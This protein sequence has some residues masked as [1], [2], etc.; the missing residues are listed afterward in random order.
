MD[1]AGV[2]RNGTDRN[3]LTDAADYGRLA[4]ET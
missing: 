3:P 1:S 4:F 2:G